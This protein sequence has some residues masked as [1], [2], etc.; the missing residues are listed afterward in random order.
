MA[1]L[2]ADSDLNAK[3]ISTLAI[4]LHRLKYHTG[5]SKI[6][7]NL[8]WNSHF[9]IKES[10]GPPKYVRLSLSPLSLLALFFPSIACTDSINYSQRSMSVI[11]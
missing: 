2:K 10:Y 4:S 9:P 1:E 5:R 6:H 8:S 7:H 3:Q 11:S